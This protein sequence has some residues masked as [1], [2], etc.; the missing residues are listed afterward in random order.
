MV[1]AL[2]KYMPDFIKKKY[3]NLE[4]VATANDKKNI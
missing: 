3:A 4:L 2:Y 1:F